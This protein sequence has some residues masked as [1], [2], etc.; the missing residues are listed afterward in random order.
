MD[1]ISITRTVPHSFVL[2]PEEYIAVSSQGAQEALKTTIS[3]TSEFGQRYL[4]CT[5]GAT[6]TWGSCL[7]N[8]QVEKVKPKPQNACS[9]FLHFVHFSVKEP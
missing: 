4:Y 6:L 8:E 2:W 7:S 1:D 5:D 3:L 9:L